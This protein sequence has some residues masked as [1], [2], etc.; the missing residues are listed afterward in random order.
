MRLRSSKIASVPALIAV[1]AI[2]ASTLLAQDEPPPAATPEV[3]LPMEKRSEL[4]ASQMTDKA[5]ELRSAIAV[6]EKRVEQLREAA[7]KSKDVIKLN[8]INDK[9]MQIVALAKI[10]EKE[11]VELDAAIATGAEAERYHRFSMITIAAEKVGI[12]RSE[13]EACV[14]EEIDYLGPLDVGT[15]EPD[16]P[17]DPTVDDPFENDDLEPPGYASPFE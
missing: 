14:G 3:V 10:A 1:L 5:A 8:C 9:R 13:A 2:G 12:L 17:D 4:T 11:E 15:D 16:V 6:D 7:R